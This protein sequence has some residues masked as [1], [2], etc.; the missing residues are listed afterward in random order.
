[1]T[2]LTQEEFHAL[3]ALINGGQAEQ[4]IARIQQK[5]AQAPTA[6][7]L[8]VLL[9]LA[10]TAHGELEPALASYEKALT[11]KP[12]YFD[13]YLNSGVALQRLGKLTQAAESYTKAITLNPNHPTALLNL[14]HALK[15]LGR[16]EE[17]RTYLS[18][19]VA[20]DPNDIRSLAQLVFIAKTLGQ[21]YRDYSERILTLG[22][23]DFD[24]VMV[25]MWAALTLDQPDLAFSLKADR[26]NIPDYAELTTLYSQDTLKQKL[27][28][29]PQ[30]NGTLPRNSART[31]LFAGADGIYAE[32]FAHDLIGSALSKCPQSDFH[33]HIINPGKF[34]PAAA[35]A[36]FP[37]DRLT[38]TS[39]E[40]TKPCDK[41]LFSLRRWLRL[42]Q[43]QYSADRIIIAL[44]MDS[45]VN[46]DVVAGLPDT[47]DVL[48][49]ERP[50]EIFAHQM[51]NAGFLAIAPS[52]R[53]FIDYLAAYILYVEQMYGAK[54]FDD[55]I[56][57]V[58]ARTWLRQNRPDISI[59]SAP[60]HMMDWSGTH[61]A[62]SLIW[63]EKG[64]LK[65]V[66]S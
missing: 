36:H 23:N 16:L 47:F 3:L 40:E 49:Y 38:W 14:G 15:Q 52:G 24:S 21:P 55:Q 18:R 7:M 11:L 50:D 25:K 61:P 27:D 63:H 62:G 2:N 58:A 34:D 43:I 48:L 54:W 51:I 46:G 22:S 64:N 45:I 12:N 37:Q 56:G 29:L 26:V 9:G 31:L 35:F 41:I 10:L 19:A 57:I 4:A 33:L 39:E 1:M 28:A 42:A 8:H 44:D 66:K 59:Q 53:A 30:L 60:A 6:A 13:A 17:A 65:R 20:I 32:R 5:I